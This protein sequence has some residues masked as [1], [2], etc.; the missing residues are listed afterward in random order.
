MWNSS[1]IGGTFLDLWYDISTYRETKAISFITF[2]NKFSF[3]HFKKKKKKTF[4]S[5]FELR[6]HK[7]VLLEA[8]ATS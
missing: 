2:E 6:P 8:T 1:Y 3:L 4:W 7:V 5:L